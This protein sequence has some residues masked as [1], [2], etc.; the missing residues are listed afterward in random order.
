[1]ITSTLL[2][3]SLLLQPIET[4]P[5]PWFGEDKLKHFF[6]SFVVTSLSAS[7]A[8][9]AGLEPRTSVWFGMGTAAGAGLYKEITD[10]RA[11]NPFSVRDLVWDS[12]GIAAAGMVLDSAR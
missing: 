5:D 2:V 8:R 7:G 1:M 3:A 9:L 6:T 4:P 11:G 12:G 10:S